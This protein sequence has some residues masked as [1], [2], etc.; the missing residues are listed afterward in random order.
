MRSEIRPATSQDKKK[1]HVRRMNLPTK[2][3][4]RNDLALQSTRHLQCNDMMLHASDANIY[5]NSNMAGALSSCRWVTFHCWALEASFQSLGDHGHESKAGQDHTELLP[6]PKI[7][8][9]A[10]PFALRTG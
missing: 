6:C 10:P 9:Q 1:R 4:Q 3:H 8:K 5:F 2:P 7:E